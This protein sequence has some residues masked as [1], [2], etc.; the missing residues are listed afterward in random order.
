MQKLKVTLQDSPVDI[1]L[2]KYKRMFTAACVAL[3]DVSDELGCN[4]NDGGSE[5]IIEAIKELRL[6]AKRYRWIR[7]LPNADSLNVKFMGS[8]LDT[9][10]DASLGG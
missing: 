6:D 4:P 1:E 10:I 2:A 9:V 8:D 7:E 3:G 5:P